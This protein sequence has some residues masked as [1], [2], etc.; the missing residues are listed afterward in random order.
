[1]KGST[2]RDREHKWEKTLPAFPS[3][4]S[5]SECGLVNNPNNI[6]TVCIPVRK[7]KSDSESHD[8]F[9]KDRLPG[10]QG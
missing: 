5:C 9:W 4:A 1:M 6:G 2:Q 3:F 10:T 7:I 8:Q